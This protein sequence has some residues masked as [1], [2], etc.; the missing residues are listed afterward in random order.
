MMTR[1]AVTKEGRIVFK[2][3][4]AVHNLLFIPLE[5]SMEELRALL[6]EC[7][8]P[9]SIYS[10]SDRPSDP[11]MIPDSDMTDLRLI[12]DMSFT[13]PIFIST[14]ENELK[15][16]THIVVTHGPLKGVDGKLVRKNKKY[17]LVK[18]FVGMAVMVAVS[19]WCCKALND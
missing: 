19:R 2:H 10:H 18:T 12:C 8:Y 13:E 1:R 7:P 5:K 3:Y 11:Y 6:S 4:P 9:V 16:G 15:V 17:Y 14:E